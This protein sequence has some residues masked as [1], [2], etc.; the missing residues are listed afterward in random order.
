MPKD[1]KPI[2]DAN[3]GWK[4]DFYVAKK[5][6]RKR[7]GI[8][9]RSLK[10][11]ANQQA[12]KIY[13]EAWDR[14]LNPIEAPPGTPFW[15][16]AQDYAKAGH[17]A[18]FLP[19]LIAYL[20]EDVTIEEID[21]DMLAQIA[22]E[23]YP[24]RMPDT[25]RRQ[26]RVPINAVRN[27]VAGTRRKPSTDRKRVRWLTPE[28][29]ERLIEA[30][31]GL[32]LPRHP[33]PEPYTL[34]KIAFM[35]GSGARAGECFAADVDDWND[36]SQQQWIPGEEIGAGK[37]DGAARWVRLPPRA[38]ELMGVLPASGRMFRTPYGKPI[39]LV[40]GGGGQMQASFTRARD[41]AGLG[42]EVTPHILR[43]T[44]AT[45]FYA[46]NRDF[47][48]LMDHGGWTKA[49]TANRYRKLAPDDLPTRLLDHGWDFRL[50][51]PESRRSQIRAVK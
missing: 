42:D 24:G 19:K 28:E 38:V 23:V 48:A 5:R 51:D 46:A 29:A 40:Q 7:L 16:A 39:T 31:A 18:R 3:N 32:T 11:I 44:W 33:R 1:W 6:V 35:L 4:V 17:E 30:A 14:H 2:W 21:E 25:I 13:K 50:P 26:V 47:G 43:H 41:N 34:A 37:T 15:K 27:F 9:D 22:D 8:R 45:W 36:G 20:G 12:E 10:A 49:D